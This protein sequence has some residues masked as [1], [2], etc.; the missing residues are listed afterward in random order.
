M[1]LIT[2]TDV[3]FM[4][5]ALAQVGSWVE[6]PVT[7][8]EFSSVDY[9]GTTVEAG[10]PPDV[11]FGT[12]SDTARIEQIT[13]NMVEKSNGRYQANDKYITLRGSY[14]KDDMIVH[15]AGT[16]RPIDGPFKFFIGSNLLYQSVCRE[17]Q[18]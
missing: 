15:S 16:Y 14:T 3:D 4:Q 6:Q 5:T 12:R 13:S 1:V 17:V 2:G 18:T 8:F 11:T 7:V 9:S 10:D